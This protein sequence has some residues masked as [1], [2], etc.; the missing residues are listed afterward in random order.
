M[1]TQPCFARRKVLPAWWQLCMY[2]RLRSRNRN[3]RIGQGKTAPCIRHIR[4]QGI[5]RIY[6]THRHR[7]V[8]M[9]RP[10]HP[11]PTIPNQ[12][13]E[14]RVITR[15]ITYQLPST[16]LVHTHTHTHIS[17]KTRQPPRPNHLL[18]PNNNHPPQRPRL[19]NSTSKTPPP[20]PT[21]Q[22]IP[23]ALSTHRP[24]QDLHIRPKLPP[25]RLGMHLVQHPPAKHPP[26]AAA[27]RHAAVAAADDG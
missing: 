14:S 16:T 4:L 8:V 12:A 2:A 6:T 10:I 13:V 17:H 23:P 20:P 5:S 19:P 25:P 7:L 26:I 15:N 24:R 11:L 18:N 27:P 3:K 1:L 22:R 9:G 21:N